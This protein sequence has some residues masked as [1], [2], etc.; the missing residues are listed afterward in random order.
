MSAKEH[1]SSALESLASIHDHEPIKI[2]LG[3]LPGVIPTAALLGD[4]LRA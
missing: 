4:D 1:R 3:L 2:I